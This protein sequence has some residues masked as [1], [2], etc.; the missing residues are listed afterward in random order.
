MITVRQALETALQQTKRLPVE[1]LAL[2]ESVGRVLAEDVISDIDMPPFAR[3]TMDGYALCSEDIRHAPQRLRVVGVIPAGAY[4]NFSLQP[5]QAA[6]IMTGAPLP[7]GADAV[8]M[9]EKTR[10]LQDDAA[11]EILESVS[12]GHNVSPLGSEARRGD[13]V[14][15]AGAFISPGV[16]GL[17]AA[18]GKNSVAVYRAPSVGILATGDELVDIT[19]KPGLGQIRNSNS[20]TLYA[21]VKQ[22]GGKPHLLGVAKDTRVNLRQ[23]IAEGLQFDL[24]LATGGV[25][26]GDLDLVEEVFAEFGLEIFFDKIAMK[27]GKPVMLARSARGGLVFGLPGNPVSAT[28]VFEVLVRPVM[29]KMMGFPIYQNHMVLASLTEPFVNRSGREHYAPSVTWYE[30][31]RFLVR[32][33]KSK[34]SGDVVTYAKSNSYLICPIERTDFSPNENVVVMLRPDFFYG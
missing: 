32:P 5:M 3:S 31:K 21:Q 19:A 6:K 25:S 14:L 23:K 33:L 24:F 20:F 27:P 7:V 30:E 2:L 15:P 16:I 8:Q 1:T 22:A 11:V 17:L 4:P 29:R 34:G 28:T 26:M 9:V 13:V 12:P 10:P 18:V